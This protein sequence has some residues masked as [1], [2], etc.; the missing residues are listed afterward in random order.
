MHYSLLPLIALQFS[1]PSFVLEQPSQTH[2]RLTASMGEPGFTDPVSGSPGEWV[3]ENDLNPLSGIASDR[4]H[5]M[6]PTYSEAGCDFTVTFSA[7]VQQGNRLRYKICTTSNILLTARP[8]EKA[9]PDLKRDGLRLTIPGRV[10]DAEGG[11]I[12][13][14][15]WSYK[16]NEVVG[17]K[18]AI[19]P[20]IPT[21]LRGKLNPTA[22]TLRSL[23][24]NQ[25]WEG[26]ESTFKN[27]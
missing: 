23:Y 5:P 1:I 27:W 7:S 9:S 15:L 21:S 3:G 14:Y 22:V 13:L 8:D 2:Y 18:R 11:L 26:L 17:Y 16:G 19:F 4:E 12:V 6:G 25:N 24:H 10:K 20:I